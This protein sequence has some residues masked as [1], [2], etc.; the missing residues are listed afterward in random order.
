VTLF[1]LAA[2]NV[3]FGPCSAA[4]STLLQL[5]FSENQGATMNSLVS[6]SGSI[7]FAIVSVLLGLVADCTNPG[8]ALLVALS[9]NLLIIAL[10]VSI[11]REPKNQ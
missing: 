1:F 7:L 10:Y 8:F 2:T 11:F 9:S 5:E 6:L 3:I 4:R